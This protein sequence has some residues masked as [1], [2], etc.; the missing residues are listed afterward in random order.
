MIKLLYA[1]TGSLGLTPFDFL[2][3]AHCYS[4]TA[5]VLYSRELDHIT[6]FVYTKYEVM[7]DANNRY[8]ST[9]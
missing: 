7:I 4:A 3:L 2:P 1:S 8:G 5:G 6:Y 9:S